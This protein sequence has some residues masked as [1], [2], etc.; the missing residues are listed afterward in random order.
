MQQGP[1]IWQRALSE[2]QTIMT[3][4][5]YNQWLQ[6][7]RYVDMQGSTLTVGVPS[8]FNKEYLEKKIPHLIG[9]TMQGIGCG[10]L[11]L[12]YTVVGDDAISSNRSPRTAARPQ[13][14]ARGATPLNGN[15]G[16]HE[17]VPISMSMGSREI[18]SPLNARYVF[19]TFIVGSSNRFVHAASFAV[20]EN[21]AE[22]FNP[23]FIWG[24]V[25]LGK[26]HLLHAIGNKVLAEQPS[27]TVLYTSSEKFL[28]DM[29]ASIQKG[30]NEEFRNKYRGVDILL[31]DDVQFIAGKEG[32][33]D[34]FFHTFNAL[35]EAQKQ[36][37]MTS[38]RHPKAMTTLEDRLRSRFEWG[39]IADVQQPDLETRIAILNE[40]AMNQ[41]T[42]VPKA[43]IDYIAKRVQ[44]NIRELEGTLTRLT[45]Q[46]SM[47]GTP[48][49]LELAMGALESQA[50]NAR[51][52]KPTLEEVLK[53]VIDHYKV[54][55]VAMLSPA[56]DRA[57]A[58]PRQIAM[59]LMR[60]EVEASLPRI[61]AFLGNRDHSTVMHG[62]DK[63]AD[64]LK[65]ENAQLRKDITTIRN[66]LY[67]SHER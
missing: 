58:L 17:A 31:I 43:V 20:A 11:N 54:D 18:S 57:I 46:A 29:I 3:Q 27:K 41:P 62:C 9:K 22:R 21:P 30:Q 6:N 59:Y 66:A 56:R 12:Q 32:M 5:N 47:L 65:N 28:N 40:K 64:E 4:A 60:E 16:S 49:T 55:R 45:A 44:S 42:P 61:G 36:I 10:H 50:G 15:G 26:T 2:L 13:H 39:L 25:G 51:R 24:G 67:E 8:T 19:E 52:A 1:M 35:Y 23:L 33:Q 34:E 53:A 7:T 48:V 14:D 37:V 38:D 63:I